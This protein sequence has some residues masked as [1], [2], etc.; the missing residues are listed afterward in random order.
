MKVLSGIAGICVVAAVCGATGRA[1]TVAGHGRSPGTTQPTLLQIKVTARIDG[2]TP[3]PA[4]PVRRRQLAEIATAT[5]KVDENIFRVG[6]SLR[7]ELFSDLIVDAAVQY[8]ERLPDGRLTV[9]ATREGAPGRVYLTVDQGRFTGLFQLPNEGDLDITP[10]NGERLLISQYPRQLPLSCSATAGVSGA[11]KLTVPE[12]A[13]ADADVVSQIDVGVLYTRDAVC[14]SAAGTCAEEIKNLPGRLNDWAMNTSDVFTCS[15]INAR[16]NVVGVQELAF[17]EKDTLSEDLK[18]FD[19]PTKSPGSDVRTFRHEKKADIVLVLVSKADKDINLGLANVFDTSAAKFAEVATG[20]A[21]YGE[22]LTHYVL[23]HELGHTMGAGH[24]WFEGTGRHW[25]SHGKK[26]ELKSGYAYTIMAVGGNADRIPFFSNPD[27]TVP[28][29]GKK[30]S[31]TWFSDNAATLNGT[32][33]DVEKF[34]GGVPT[35]RLPA[36]P[37]GSTALVPTKKP[38]S[39]TTLNRVKDAT[40]SGRRSP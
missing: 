32:R 4:A 21:L 12:V 34:Q 15:R 14:G 18:A 38:E 36:I 7:F 6:T 30:K 23:T 22:A 5:H 27:V 1:G 13:A 26:I 16:V 3:P 20:V 25:T 33:D 31:G 40:R 11:G 39:V 19:D 10:Y 28:G 29:P 37:C 35:N 24:Q 9:I 17:E 2:V 8:T